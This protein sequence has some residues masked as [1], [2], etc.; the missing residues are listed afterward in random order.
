[1]WF[2]VSYIFYAVD[3][4]IDG[5]DFIPVNRTSMEVGGIWNQQVERLT[6]HRA[7]ENGELL[8]QSSF[9]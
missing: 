9:V 1:M 6:G 3:L 2:P 4:N 5:M 7:A 8:M